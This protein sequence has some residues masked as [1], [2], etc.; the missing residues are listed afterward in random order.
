MHVD[1]HVRV[2]AHVHVH[3]HAECAPGLCTAEAGVRDGAGAGVGS[4]E[5]P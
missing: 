5:G 1:V 3:V 2:N 4:D